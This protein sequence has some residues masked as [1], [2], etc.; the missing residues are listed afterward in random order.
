LIILKC[1]IA[2]NLPLLFKKDD[3]SE[4]NFDVFDSKITVVKEKMKAL[5]TS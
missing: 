2:P 3:A 5:C 1:S 4:E